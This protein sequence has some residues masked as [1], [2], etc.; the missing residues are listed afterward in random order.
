MDQQQ[1][2]K[3]GVRS[4][5]QK[6]DRARE[7]YSTIPPAEPVG[8]AF[9]KEQDDRSDVDRTDHEASLRHNT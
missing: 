5:A 6:Q 4:E 9:G 7:G 8:G 1:S 2:Q 3:T